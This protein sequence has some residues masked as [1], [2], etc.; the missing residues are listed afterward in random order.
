MS[1][2]KKRGRGIIVILLILVILAGGVFA[3][4]HMLGAPADAS[5]T[6]S[7]TVTIPQGSSTDAIAGILSDS[8]VID[9]AFRFKIFSRIEG[10][11]GKYKAGVYEVSAAMSPREIM[12]KL[13]EG[14]E[15]TLTFTIPE[16]YTLKDI[17]EVVAKTGLCTADEFLKEAAE[18]TF[19]YDFLNG[20]VQGEKRLEGFLFPSTYN[21]YKT[22]TPHEIIE[23]MLS[24]FKS[25]YD[26]AYAS[27]DATVTSG[28]G[29]AQILTVASLIEKEAK[30]DEERPIIASV[31]YNRLNSSMRLQIDATVQYA[32]GATKERLYES[33]LK[34]DSPYNTY[35]VDGLP[36]GPICSPG[37][38]AINAALN[39]A[40][41][42]YLYYVASPAKDGS[43]NF[44]SNYEQFEAYKAEYINSLD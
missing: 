22:L 26:K 33:D 41:T 29:T 5:A 36:V 11:D 6:E 25:V 7:V 13:I 40:S 8:G 4:L 17:A 24:T 21:I 38:K 20:G 18:G 1:K 32:L 31:I 42:D 35:K 23:K 19:D 3:F 14:N 9:S 44:A 27:S 30:L 2:S 34:V 37:E 16:G 28:F 10:N 39:P 15:D 43:H 12:D